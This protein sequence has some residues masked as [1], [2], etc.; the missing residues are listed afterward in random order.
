MVTNEQPPQ[1]ENLLFNFSEYLSENEVITNELSTSLNRTPTPMLGYSYYW[2]PAALPQMQTCIPGYESASLLEASSCMP[3]Y[4]HY[5]QTISLSE[6][7]TG[8][9]GYQHHGQPAFLTETPNFLVIDEH[10]EQPAF[11]EETSTFM[12]G[13]QYYGQ[14]QEKSFEGLDFEVDDLEN[15]S[16][17][18]FT[19]F[20]ASLFL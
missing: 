9:S 2:Q 11:L 14:R 15:P 8:M 17:E 6:T 12:P 20:Q 19:D 3:G 5:D 1:F 4:Q 13:Y 18:R 10:D 7:S 16:Q